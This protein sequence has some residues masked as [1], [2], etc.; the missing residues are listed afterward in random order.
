MDKEFID[1]LHY[2][3]GRLMKQ[4]HSIPSDWDY[5]CA[6]CGR[7]TPTERGQIDHKEDCFGVLALD[8]LK[9]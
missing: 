4:F 8:K 2:E 5:R 3:I 6:F 9:T 7:K 1:K